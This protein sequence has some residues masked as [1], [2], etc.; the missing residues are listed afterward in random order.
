MPIIDSTYRYRPNGAWAKRSL[1][2]IDRIVIHHTAVGYND[3][4][5]E[6]RF[7]AIMR[8]HV[9]EGWPGISYHY[10]IGRSGNTYKFNE[11]DD[12]T[13]T[14]SQNVNSLAICL[15]GYFHPSVNDQPTTAQLTALQSLLDELTTRRPDIPAGRRDVVGHRNISRIFGRPEWSTACPGDILFE[16]VLEYQRTGQIIIPGAGPQTL[17][18]AE[19]M[20]NQT[21]NT[22]VQIIG[23]ITKPDVRPGLSPST[24]GHWQH[25]LLQGNMIEI[26]SIMSQLNRDVETR[27]RR[28]RDLESQL[29]QA[30]GRLRTSDVQTTPVTETHPGQPPVLTN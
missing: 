10:M 28:I 30:Q 13:Y 15:D 24:V 22:A 21:V 26:A 7:A 27:E 16:R 2:Q 5:D 17:T 18:K 20:Y 3:Q 1:A 12:I 8:F 9:N 4:S 14:D 29:Q 25:Q 6:D 11:L 23:D 19:I